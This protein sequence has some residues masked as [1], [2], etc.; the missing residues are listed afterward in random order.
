MGHVVA[1]VDR[2]QGVRPVGVRVRLRVGQQQVRL[3]QVIHVEAR[4]VGEDVRNVGRGK[5]RRR[6]SDRSVT[7]PADRHDGNGGHEGGGR[8]GGH[9][10]GGGVVRQVVR[11]GGGGDVRVRDLGDGDGVA[12]G[13][14]GLDDGLEAVDG[15]GGVL[16]H[17][18]AAV[19]VH[20]RVLPLHD[21][22]VPRLGVRLLVARQGVA[23]AVL[24]M[25]LRPRLVLRAIQMIV[26]RIVSFQIQ[27]SRFNYCFTRLHCI[28]LK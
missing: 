14:D 13:G 24:V 28:Q 26:I 8:A 2:Q 6:R 5:G 21:V 18:D 4:N 9:V 25:E 10:E 23:H 3:R 11:H 15:V 17:P 12:V 7:G 20:E 19:R 27:R 22:A 1:L 16:H